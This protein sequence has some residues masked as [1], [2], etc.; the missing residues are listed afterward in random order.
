MRGS[1]A[2][3]ANLGSLPAVQG[4]RGRLLWGATLLGAPQRIGQLPAVL[5]VRVA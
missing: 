5:S 2:A 4:P 1:P 3:A